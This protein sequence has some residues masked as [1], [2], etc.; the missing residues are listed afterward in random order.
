[1]RAEIDEEEQK[2]KH[3]QNQ[4]QNKSI[5]QS[6]KGNTSDNHQADKKVEVTSEQN[7]LEQGVSE[8]IVR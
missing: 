5:A 1:M 2:Q 8:A 7:E 4:N 3:N 6:S